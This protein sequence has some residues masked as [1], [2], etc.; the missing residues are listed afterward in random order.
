MCFGK[1]ISNGL[2]CFCPC[3]L[4]CPSCWRTFVYCTDL[5]DN[6]F[7]Q[8]KVQAKYNSFLMRPMVLQI[9]SV[10][11]LCL[12]VEIKAQRTLSLSLSHTHTHT[13]THTARTPATAIAVNNKLSFISKSRVCVFYQHL[14]NHGWL[15]S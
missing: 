9:L 3:Y 6:I 4:S 5:E 8:I 7:L 10:S 11:F 13:H 14:W 15:T 2:L 12:H 1:T